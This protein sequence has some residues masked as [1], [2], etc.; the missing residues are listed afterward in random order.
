[1]HNAFTVLKPHIPAAEKATKGTVLLATVR[2][3]VHDIGKSIV[4]VLVENHGYRV[5][6]LGKN[7]STI[8]IINQAEAVKEIEKILSEN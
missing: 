7:V 6:D 3:D 4:A 1:M 5:V 8:E 2:G